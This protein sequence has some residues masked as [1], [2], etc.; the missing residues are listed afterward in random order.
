MTSKRDL[1][2]RVRDRQA[3]T[4]ESYVTARRHVTAAGQPTRATAPDAPRVPFVELIDLDDE[5]ARLGIRCRAA[6]FPALAARVDPTRLLERLR[7]ALLS[8]EGD[9]QTELF[10]AVALRGERPTSGALPWS[11]SQLAEARQF[12]SRA[13]AG[14]GGASKGGR[15]LALH[16]AGNRGPETVVCLIWHPTL[17]SPS[18][19][20]D[21][22]PS[23]VFTLPDGLFAADPDIARIAGLEVVLSPW[24]LP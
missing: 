20:I 19:C 10:R 22:E 21:R 6:I 24:I 13:R 3:R 8:T 17:R 11:Y 14:I 2:R 1:K 23:L 7:D 9:P 4:G 18:G 12:A 5:A 16:V 15:M